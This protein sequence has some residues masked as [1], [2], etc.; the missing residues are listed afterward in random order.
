MLTINATKFAGLDE[1][2]IYPFACWN[3]KSAKL[4]SC[5]CL[6]IAWFCAH[7]AL[8]A[9]R[10]ASQSLFFLVLGIH[11]QGFGNNDLSPKFL[12]K[13]GGGVLTIN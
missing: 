9:E 2:P 13:W 10:Y 1:I 4:W 3:L 6:S 7:L 12:G 11:Q 5:F 8:F